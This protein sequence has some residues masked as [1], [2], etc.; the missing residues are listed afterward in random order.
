MDEIY[1]KKQFEAF[2]NISFDDTV[3]IINYINNKNMI[4]F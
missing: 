4:F 3:M 2:E 1:S